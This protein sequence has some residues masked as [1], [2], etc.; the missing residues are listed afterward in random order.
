M[1]GANPSHPET[2]AT[3]G[4]GPGVS[5]RKARY[6]GPGVW[7]TLGDAAR[8]STATAAR[9]TI[10]APPARLLTR[11]IDENQGSWNSP[12]VTHAGPS[13]LVEDVCKVLLELILGDEFRNHDSCMPQ[14][15]IRPDGV[16]LP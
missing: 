1:D 9:A 3:A 2:S 6:G 15:A 16:D 4:C 11:M 8:R 13:S 10:A 5:G 14:L 7:A 12:N